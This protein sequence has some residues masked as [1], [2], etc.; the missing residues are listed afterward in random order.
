MAVKY[1]IYIILGYLS[2][3]VLYAYLIPRY[4]SG[5]DI[6]EL[7]DDNNPGTAN[8]FVYAGFG[9]GVIVLLLELAKGFLPVYIAKGIL[10]KGRLCFSLI[11]V[12]PVVGHAMPLFNRRRGG[13]CIAVSFGVLLGLY[14]ELMP[15]VIL[16][17]VYIFF[18]VMLVIK[19]HLLRSI[20][21]FLMFAFLIILFCREPGVKL[22]CLFI[23]AIVIVQHIR[24]KDSEECELPLLGNVRWKK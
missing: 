15:A 6:R 12:S 18:S 20:A 5:I 13:K 2:G 16:A 24:S 19:P 1:F 3:S 23:A 10:S 17:A 11:M 4:F 14:P 9:V 8:A 7:S 21:T 22:G